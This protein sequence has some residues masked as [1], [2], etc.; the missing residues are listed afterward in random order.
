MFSGL[1]IRNIAH[2]APWL[3]TQKTTYDSIHINSKTSKTTLYGSETHT[4]M[5]I[6][7]KKSKEELR[8]DY[9]A[10]EEGVSDWGRNTQE[11]PH[12]C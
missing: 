6:H 1:Q 3:T 12:C 11:F 7:T 9:D 10:G 8:K 2:I 5:V 4:N